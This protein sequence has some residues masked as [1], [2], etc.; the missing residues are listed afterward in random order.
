MK[1]L[2][3]FTICSL[4]TA[5]LFAQERNQADVSVTTV[6]LASTT[7]TNAAVTAKG[8]R[9]IPVGQGA[10]NN[11]NR[12]ATAENIRC[13]ITVHNENDDDAYGVVVVAVLPVEVSVVGISSTGT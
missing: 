1:K 7:P 13:T 8:N 10:A 2:F 9:A 12:L 6:T 11:T 4:I 5:T 3:F